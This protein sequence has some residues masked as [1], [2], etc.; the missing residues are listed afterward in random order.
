MNRVKIRIAVSGLIFTL[1]ILLFCGPEKISALL[2]VILP[3][4]QFVPATLRTFTDPA[5]IF[6]FGFAAI[7]LV[8]LIFGRVYCSFLCPLGALQDFFIYCSKKAGGNGSHSFRKP[9]NLL[10]YTMLGIIIIT[11]ALGF[12]S[13]LSLLDPYSITGRLMTQFVQ[14]FLT[15]S[16][17]TVVA[18]LKYFH[19][20]HFSKDTAPVVYSALLISAGFFIVILA[21]SLK[22]GRLYCNTVCPVGALLGWISR[23][24]L[25]R[26]AIDATHC[27][28]CL[29]CASVCK[30]GC[31]DVDNQ[32]I[33]SS[34]CVGCFNCLEACPQSVV[35]YGRF[36]KKSEVFWSPARR[37]FIIGVVVAAGS[38]WVM[39]HSGIRHL[40]SLRNVSAHPPVTPPGSVGLKRFTASC[41]ACHLC[42][43]IC[44]TNVLTPSLSDYGVGGLLQPRMNYPDSYCEY[45]CNLCGQ[46][47][48]TGA[49]LPI[50]LEEK[51]ITQI[52]EV[53][54]LED[55]CV[56]YVNHE[57]CG[58]CVEVCPTKTITFID[59]GN[60]LYPVVDTKYCIG[61][62]ACSKACP[63]TPKSIVVKAHAVH[64]KAFRHSSVSTPVP[65]KRSVPEE[66]PF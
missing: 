35:R 1:F 64:K 14:P 36:R 39:F 4:F 19:V 10:R 3:P 12:M 24:S 61:C 6:V 47:C 30:A 57:N 50:S 63:T 18:I 26:F 32:S 13:L 2:A 41:S 7:F 15:W 38:V 34:R 59:K 8:T 52:A 55:L 56:V 27:S 28:R 11:A 60:I 5:V 49:I 42:V 33:D 53:D 48:P 58:A 40:L 9:R 37:S 65:A 43:S 22:Y 21:M 31:I 66:F 23:V 25:F 45:D 20:Y 54:L 44:P 29:S 46:V 17:N 16:Y 62:G 51:S